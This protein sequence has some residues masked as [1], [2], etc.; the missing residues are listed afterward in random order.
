MV[1]RIHFSFSTTGTRVIVLLLLCFH[2]LVVNAQ[3]GQRTNTIGRA[4]GSA[5]SLLPLN[6]ILAPGSTVDQLQQAL[7]GGNAGGDKKGDDKKGSASDAALL[8]S[9]LDDVQV[10]ACQRDTACTNDSLGSEGRPG[11]WVCRNNLLAPFSV[12]LPSVLGVTAGKPGDHCGCCSGTCPEQCR[13]PC[14]GTATANDNGVL[15]HWSLFFGL[16]NF[17]LCLDPTASGAATTVW[18]GGNIV[19]STGCLTETET[20][21]EA[22]VTESEQNVVESGGDV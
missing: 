13:C 20:E 5:L 21:I 8:E 17:E 18:E 2:F 10:L 22:I 14:A 4:F 9:T 12:C 19:C 6:D 1:M 3:R 15:T 16:V 7:G 11:N